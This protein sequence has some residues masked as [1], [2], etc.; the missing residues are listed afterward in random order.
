MDERPMLRGVFAFED[1]ET[2]EWRRVVLAD[3]A[4][5]V[6]KFATKSECEDFIRKHCWRG[7]NPDFPKLQHVFSMLV[8]WKQITD[9]L[10]PK[11]AEY[12]QR[13]PSEPPEDISE[14]N[15]F[16]QGEGF[17]VAEGVDFRVNL[18]FHRRVRQLCSVAGQRWL[19]SLFAHV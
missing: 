9:I 14:A 12:D 6:P 15:R 7:S 18:P 17:G 10:I 11:I 5:G 13:F 8:D 19:C 16:M 3:G 4:G 2:P 1:E